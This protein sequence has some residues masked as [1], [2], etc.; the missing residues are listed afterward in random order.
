M[1]RTEFLFGQK[2]ERYAHLLEPLARLRIY[3]ANKLIAHLLSF[4]VYDPN[5][6][7]V[8]TEYNDLRLSEAMEA[9]KLWEKI[10]NDGKY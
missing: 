5:V 1:T 4:K 10:L 9:R 7:S 2:P 8:F 6:R 3:D